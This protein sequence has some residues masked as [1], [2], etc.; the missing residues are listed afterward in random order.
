MNLDDLRM[1]S[2]EA[3][4]A[5]LIRFI[6]DQV[7]DILRWDASRR[8]ELARGLTEIGLDSLN[9]VELQFRLQSTF[10]FAAQPEDFDQPSIEGLAARL[11]AMRIQ[12]TAAA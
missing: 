3:R 5:L 7:L 12:L 11:L 4:Q 6:E 8:G 9:A 10:G 2:P 1:A